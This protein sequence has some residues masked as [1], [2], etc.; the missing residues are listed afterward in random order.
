M[1]LR[2][3]VRAPELVGRGGWVNANGESFSI[4][5][6][7]GRIVVLDFW[8]SSC[9]NCVHVM[10][11]LRV[12]EERYSR[13]QVIILGIHSPKFEHE[14]DHDA[15]VAAVMRHGI[16]HPVLDDPDLITWRGYGVR[17]W[18]TIVVV[19]QEGYI[20]YVAAGEQQ[21]PALINVI[22]SLLESAGQKQQSHRQD[23]VSGSK[24]TANK[25]WYPSKL[26]RALDGTLFLANTGNHNILQLAADGDKVLRQIGSGIRGKE[27]GNLEEAQF[28]EPTAVLNLD[29]KLS[30]QLPYDMIVADRGNH[31]LRTVSLHDGEV[32]TLAIG[33]W[34]PWDIVY[35]PAIDRL[36][37]AIA[38]RHLIASMDIRT[39][40]VGILAGSGREGIHD[41]DARRAE[42]AQPSA[43]AAEPG[44][45]GSLWVIDAETSA[46]RR[47]WSEGKRIFVETAVGRGLFDFG[48]RDGPAGQALLQHPQGVSLDKPGNVIIADT[49]N[50]AIRKYIPATRQVSTIIDG[51]QEPTDVLTMDTDLLVVESAASRITWVA[52]NV[53]MAP[54]Q[55]E[56]TVPV[57]GDPIVVTPRLDMVIHLS[58][59]EPMHIDE[60]TENPARVTITSTPNSL[61]VE[62]DGQSSEL[63]R[64][65]KLDQAI[66]GG[67]IH[68]SAAVATCDD[69]AGICT[70][71][72]Q[73]WNLHV[74]ISNS[75]TGKIELILSGPPPSENL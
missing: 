22:N 53:Q 47:V 5:N 60:N 64:Q 73:D 9:I 36:V 8:T 49:F 38:G 14:G 75:G 41:G 21:L 23:S 2:S 74:M 65:L 31:A 10:E 48:H 19:N 51:L 11:E 12:L 50:G 59:P 35:W 3:K 54:K 46:L 52:L 58:L 28:S 25:I 1:V 13:D 6:L 7:R 62:G 39:G 56:S 16:D 4:A 29:G 43:L 18:P 67:T 42:F 55:K 26:A 63:R 66:E 61:L 69:S 68:V 57:K 24:A 45:D 33:L 71:M 44:P 30:S 70:L 37:I 17:A 40:E 20:A 72:T 15:V 34:S 27:D 32:K